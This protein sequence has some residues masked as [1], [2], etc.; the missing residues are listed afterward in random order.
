MK[1]NLLVIFAFLLLSVVIF[2]ESVGFLPSKQVIYSKN[3]SSGE[4]SNAS[5]YSL[6]EQYSSKGFCF[7]TDKSGLKFLKEVNAKLVHV[8]KTENI[9]NLYYYSNKI[10]TYQMI[11]S[12][13]VNIHVATTFDKVTVGIPLIY[14]GY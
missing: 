8:S 4:F 2:Y 7:K 14:Y 5:I 10:K 13:K 1:N 12:H 9:E 11:N 6:S 3:Y